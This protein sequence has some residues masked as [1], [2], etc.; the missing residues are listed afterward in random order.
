MWHFCQFGR[1]RN[2]KAMETAPRP[3]GGKRAKG[4]KGVAVRHDLLELDQELRRAFKLPSRRVK[5][6]G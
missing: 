6:H 2:P 1:E 5:R 4:G 3:K